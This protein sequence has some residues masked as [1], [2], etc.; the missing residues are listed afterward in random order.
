MYNY[1]V[2]SKSDMAAFSWDRSGQFEI[3]GLELPT[4]KTDLLT[5]GLESKVSPRFAPSG[6]RLAYAQ[7]YQG[8]EKYDIFILSIAGGET[9]NLTPNTDETIYPR[10]RWSPDEKQLAFASNRGG[11]FSIYTIS[12]QGGKPDRVSDHEFSDSSPEWSPDGK[13]LA[14]EALVSAQDEG[15]FVVPAKGGETMRLAERGISV[16]S[17]SPKWSPDGRAIAFTSSERGSSD[18]AIWD[19]E[20]GSVRWVTDSRYECYD[21][22]W[23]PDGRGLAYV[24]NREGNQGIAIHNLE[25]HGTEI[26]EVEAGVHSQLRFGRDRATMF[27]TFS[28]PRHPPDLWT[29]DLKARTFRQLTNSLPDSIDR[30]LLVSGSSIS[31][32]SKDEL[33][34]QAWLFLPKNSDK[35]NLGSA[36]VYVHGG[37]TAQFTNDWRP[38]VQHLVDLG[39][40]VIAPNYRGSSGF[41]RK[42]RDANRFVLGEKDLEDLVAAADYLAKERL[43]DPKRIGVLGGSYGG[44]LT[45]CALTKFPEHWAVGSAMVPFLNWFTEIENEREDLRYWDLEN[46]GDPKKDHER[47]REASPIFFIDRIEAPVQIIAGEHDPR[48]PVSE[49]KQAEKEFR[50]LG[51]VFDLVIYEDEGHGFRK[52]ENRVDAYKRRAKFLTEHLRPR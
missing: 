6:N 28:S 38:V 8:D 7:D 24:V 17:S 10:V 30:S 16:E 48:C 42:F 49:T 2:S 3:Y 14:F 15:V 46:M 19:L 44:Y 47:L 5:K 9:W 33:E 39:H 50:K 41:G 52:I 27:F 4:G 36:L 23:F 35:T 37:P 1:D 25:T 13:R 40:V 21:P 43:A 32:Q 12:S 18:I 31:F 26:L 29:V 45:M 11:R 20:H 34:I 22:E 51:K